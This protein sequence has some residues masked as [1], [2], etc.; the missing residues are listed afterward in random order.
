MACPKCG[1]KETYQ[2]DTGWDGEQS[3]EGL[4]RCA[5]CGEIFDIEDQA[6]EDEDTE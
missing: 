1:C 3:E 2:Y 4:E 6:P 5:A